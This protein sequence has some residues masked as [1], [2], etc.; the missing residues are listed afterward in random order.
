MLVNFE[1]AED[2]VVAIS[3][4]EQLSVI[5]NVC[6]VCIEPLGGSISDTAIQTVVSIVVDFGEVL[7]L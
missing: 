6:F 5:V 1:F 3:T 7:H 4:F 2:L